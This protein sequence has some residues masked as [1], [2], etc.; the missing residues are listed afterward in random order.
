MTYPLLSSLI[1]LPVVA[2]TI[3]LVWG[4]QRSASFVRW[5]TL[6]VTLITLSLSILMYQN[7]NPELASMQF[8]ESYVWIPLLNVKYSVGVDGIS[9]PLV[10]LTSYTHLLV[11]LAAWQLI[12]K[13][14]AEYYAVFLIIQATIYGVFC[15]TD[16]I[17]YFIFWEAML[18]P[19]YLCIGIW[20]S[21]D[22]SYAAIKFFL[23]TFLGSTLLLIS[24]LYLGT[25]AKNFDIASFYVIKLSFLEQILIFIA[26]LLSFGVKVP[27]WPIHTWL[28]DA[29]TQAPAGGSIIL[30]AL[31]LKVGAYGFFRFCLPIVPDAC[32]YL[33]NIMV[34]VS[35]IAVVYIGAV[36]LAQTDMKRLIAYSSVAHMGF[37]TLGLFVIYNIFRVTSHYAD[38]AVVLEGAM[39]QMIAHAFGSGAM[40]LAFGIIYEKVHTRSIS[41]FG[42]LAT[43][44]PYFAAFFMIFALA[45]VGLPGTSGFVGEFMII[46]GVLKA[47]FW[48]SFTA[49]VTLI[50]SAS[51][52]LWMYKRVF[53]GVVG[54]K[55]SGPLTDVNHHEKL[56]L[57]LLVVAIFVI[58]VYPDFLLKPMH[59][60]I[61]NLLAASFKS[62][63]IL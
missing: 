39:I 8:V 27:M 31:M 23:Y 33:S 10:A 62:K 63:L 57:W 5:L 49:A 59:A 9:M 22:R 32:L 19:M 51:Y 54:P 43:K 45:N 46:L 35:L 40:F 55:L 44:M 12:K 6:L 58:G 34:I 47:N 29:H 30:A 26:F 7:F 56:V 20:G 53:Y 24:I 14:I 48:I 41:D 17:L 37:V 16:A 38:A 50:I 4:N 25:V 21:E 3:I 28:P 52:T 60:T 1:W 11:V 18:I 36:A 13:N 42:G 2:A 15:A 61:N